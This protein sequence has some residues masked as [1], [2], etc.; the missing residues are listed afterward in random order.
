MRPQGTCFLLAVQ[1]LCQAKFMPA[2]TPLNLCSLAR[3]QMPGQAFRVT[4]EMTYVKRPVQ[5]L[6]GSGN[7][8]V[9]I[10]T[11]MFQACSSSVCLWGV[12]RGQATGNLPSRGLTPASSSPWPHMRLSPVVPELCLFKRTQKL[13]F[14]M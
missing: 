7:L 13:V 4:S 9:V 10:R 1:T 3:K 12:G 6:V 5:G 2:L 8:I 11:R 14:L